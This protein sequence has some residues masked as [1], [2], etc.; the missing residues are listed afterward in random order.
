[1]TEEVLTLVYSPK[2]KVVESL[3]LAGDSCLLFLVESPQ[4]GWNAKM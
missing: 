4:V 2:I 3:W 1:M